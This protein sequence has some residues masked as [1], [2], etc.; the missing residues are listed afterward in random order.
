M[1][2]KQ[3]SITEKAHS[4]LNHNFDK[5]PYPSDRLTYVIEDA[6]NNI[7]KKVEVY[8]WS[9]MILLASIPL[10]STLISI[11]LKM[12]DKDITLYLSITLT[13]ITILNSIFK[14]RERFREACLISISID[15]FANDFLFNLARMA[16]KSE[17][18]IQEYCLKQF[19]EFIPYRRQLI[20]LFLPEP[21]EG[22]KADPK[23]GNQSTKP[24]EGR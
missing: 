20:D 16:D 21:T 2:T 8:K 11:L 12:G 3:S 5:K 15:K 19:D 6:Q 14:P 7:N 4:T 10:L 18:E 17:I 23:A 9:G 13:T 24:S 1:K 22:T